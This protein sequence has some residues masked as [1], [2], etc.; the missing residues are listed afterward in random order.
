ARDGRR[1][2]QRLDAVQIC[3]AWRR[4]QGNQRQRIGGHAAD[5]FGERVAERGAEWQRTA[6][7]GRAQQRTGG[8][9]RGQV[10]RQV[11]GRKGR[12]RVVRQQQALRAA[13]G[14]VVVHDAALE[15]LVDKVVI[16]GIVGGLARGC[17]PDFEIEQTE[18]VRIVGP[19]DRRRNGVEEGLVEVDRLA[20][21]CVLSSNANEVE[22]AAGV[23][24]VSDL[25]SHRRQRGVARREGAA[26]HVRVWQQ[27]LV[28]EVHG[29]DTVGAALLHHNALEKLRRAALEGKV[30]ADWV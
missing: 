28:E 9:L 21:K 18:N 30:T 2:S 11:V 27:T 20:V 25:R 23:V 14:L 5:A 22:N 16:A 10:W 3:V 4:R 1:R 26:V 29:A 24:R 17:A 7:R 15:A 12:L 8:G 13:A 19:G 6:E